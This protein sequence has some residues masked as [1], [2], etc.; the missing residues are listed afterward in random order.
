MTV[1]KSA[2]INLDFNDIQSIDAQLDL[3]ASSHPVMSALKYGVKSAEGTAV[4]GAE[5]YYFICGGRNGWEEQFLGTMKLPETWSTGWSARFEQRRTE[6]AL[7]NVELWN[8]VIPE[9]HGVL[10][11]KRWPDGWG[12]GKLRPINALQ[13]LAGAAHH[14]VYPLAELQAAQLVAPT[15]LRHDS[16]WTATGCCVVG[17]SLLAHMGIRLDQAKHKITVKLHKVARDLTEHLLD[18]APQEEILLVQPP[19]EEVFHNRNFERTGRRR[20]TIFV[21]ENA[22]A[23]DARRVVVFGDSYTHDMGLAGFLSTVFQAVIFSWSNAIQWDLAERM[24]AT[25]IIWQSAE[26]FIVSVPEV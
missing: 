10:S 23:P 19:G 12:E 2:F 17:F 14:L 22:A 5:G 3:E 11:R 25:V 21:I 1:D 13:S 7:R 24:G 26:R 6:A 4:V 16:H 18:P 8:L 20:G 15:Y 9:K